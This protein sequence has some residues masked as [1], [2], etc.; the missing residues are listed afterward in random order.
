KPDNENYLWYVPKGVD[1]LRQWSGPA[2][3]VWNCIECTNIGSNRRATPAQVRAEV[4][5]SLVHGSTGLIY[6]VHRFKPTF[7]E[8]GLLDDPE[9]L[10][11]V[12]AINRQIYDLAPAL[13]SATV[14]NGATW[15][16][17]DTK[18][19]IDVMVKRRG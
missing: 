4:W 11:A 18:V 7:S 14:E 6:F 5:M 15:T 2:R 17:S 19:P 9:M 8:W 3:R 1:R 16:S 10:A 13:N 12:T